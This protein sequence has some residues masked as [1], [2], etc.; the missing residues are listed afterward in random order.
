MARSK[1]ALMNRKT[2]SSALTSFPFSIPSTPVVKKKP[3]SLHDSCCVEKCVRSL[4]T[5][6]SFL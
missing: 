1:K 6:K 4:E 2:M 3:F 5:G